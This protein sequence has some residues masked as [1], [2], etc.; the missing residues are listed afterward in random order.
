MDEKVQ[1]FF[2]CDR[3]SFSGE[4][5]WEV[6]Y[7]LSWMFSTPPEG[8]LVRERCSFFMLGTCDVSLGTYW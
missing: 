3:G 7:D 8:D 6:S 1:V 2:P 4:F 5:S